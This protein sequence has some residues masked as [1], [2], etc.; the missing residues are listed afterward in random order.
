MRFL[1]FRRIVQQKLHHSSAVYRYINDGS[2]SASIYSKYFQTF[3]KK[4]DMHDKQVQHLLWDY[5]NIKIN[6]KK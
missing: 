5:F 3:R 1:L 6:D 2:F 4:I